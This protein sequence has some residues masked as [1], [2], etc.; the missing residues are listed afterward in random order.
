MAKRLQHRKRVVAT[1]VP[2]GACNGWR[3]DYSRIVKDLLRLHKYLAAE[4]VE[5]EELGDLAG[6]D[7]FA[8]PPEPDVLPLLQ[9][10]RVNSPD[11][12]LPLKV[13]VVDVGH[14]RLFKRR[15]AGNKKKKKQ[16]LV[17]QTWRGGRQTTA[18]Y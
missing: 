5:D 17:R 4:V 18:V 11:P 8:R 14:Q 1:A 16:S 13:V 3:R 9:G 2:Q 15:T 7:V 6:L 10:P 12:E